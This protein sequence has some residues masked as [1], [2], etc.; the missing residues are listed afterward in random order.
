MKFVNFSFH[1]L[2]M[3]LFVVA[4]PLIRATIKLSFIADRCLEIFAQAGCV[5]ACVASTLTCAIRVHIY[6]HI[7]YIFY[8]IICYMILTVFFLFWNNK[9]FFVW[10]SINI[11]A[12]V[13]M[14]AC[15]RIMACGWAPFCGCESEIGFLSFFIC[16]Y[17][18]EC[19]VEF[20]KIFALALLHF[21]DHLWFWLNLGIR[22]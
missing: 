16:V 21:I 22:M 4:A 19:V 5:C 11:C 18:L 10:P 17:L 14:Y 2:L 9:Y 7:L 20:V 8:T 6:T 15:K 13:R 3:F 1:F 12:H